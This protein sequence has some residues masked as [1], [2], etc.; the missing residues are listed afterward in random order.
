MI[1]CSQLDRALQKFFD[2]HGDETPRQ[3]KNTLFSLLYRMLIDND[4]ISQYY[5]DQAFNINDMYELLD[6]LEDRK[7]SL[8]VGK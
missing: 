5:K 2:G 1:S 6:A 3:M 8:K 7:D 4:D